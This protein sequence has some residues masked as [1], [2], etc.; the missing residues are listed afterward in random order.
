MLRNQSFGLRWLTFR[1]AIIEIEDWP[2]CKI[3]LTKRPASDPFAMGEALVENVKKIR[4]SRLSK[5]GVCAS[6]NDRDQRRHTQEQQ[7]GGGGAGNPPLKLKLPPD[8]SPGKGRVMD[9]C[10]R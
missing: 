4:G 10:V 8:L 3:G 9:I 5:K 7:D 1:V 2:S 6:P